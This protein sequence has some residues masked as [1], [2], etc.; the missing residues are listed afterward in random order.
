M[1]ES[2][3]DRSRTQEHVLLEDGHSVD[4]FVSEAFSEGV[5]PME[6]LFK[7]SSQYGSAG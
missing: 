2:N 3:R 6:V 4:A 5:V 1:W 7:R